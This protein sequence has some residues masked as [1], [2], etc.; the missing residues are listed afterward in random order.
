[1]RNV[2][3]DNIIQL[4]QFLESNEHYYLVLELCEG[5]ELFHRIVKLTYFSE[6]LARHVIT[7]VAQSVRYLHEECGVV[8]RYGAFRS[9]HMHFSNR[10][11]TE[12]SSRKTSCLIQ[13]RTS[14]RRRTAAA[15]ITLTRRKKTRACL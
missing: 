9:K 12:T 4:I 13:S 3:H 7:Q 15:D 2:K 8:H 6:A 5:G 11:I 1:M 14:H 10:F